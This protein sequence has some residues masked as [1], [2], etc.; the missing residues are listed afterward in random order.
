MFMAQ[1]YIS[2]NFVSERAREVY[3]L[4]LR[5]EKRISRQL[6]WGARKRQRFAKFLNFKLINNDTK[7]F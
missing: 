2:F 3:E 5:N 7:T 1:R 4:M 6:M